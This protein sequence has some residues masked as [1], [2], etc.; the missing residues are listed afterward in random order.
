MKRL[1]LPLLA[2]SLC[3]PV[4]A[5]DY[6]LCEAMQR[7]FRADSAEQ[8]ARARQASQDYLQRT[9]PTPQQVA[10]VDADCL[11]AG[12]T[13]IE[14]ATR[15]Y[16]DGTV[17]PRWKEANRIYSEVVLQPTEH[18]QRIIDDMNEAGCF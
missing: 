3:P 2:L 12:K 5:V 1:V 11:N 16:S 9:A 15:L 4:Q 18:T 13:K 17:D 6:V 8:I 14:C 10:Q 7:R